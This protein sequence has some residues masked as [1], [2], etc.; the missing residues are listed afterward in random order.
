[1]PKASGAWAKVIGDW[2]GPD[3]RMRVNYRVEGL[4]EA[5]RRVH[6]LG[7]RIAVHA[8]IPETIDAAIEAGFDSIEHAW[9]LRDDHIASMAAR[10]I[11]LVPTLTIL[12]FASSIVSGF[13][14]GN[15]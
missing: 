2:P 12:P 11:T 5:A 9:G 7:A 3:G 6:A 15:H 10:R 8:I 4:A 1:M 13:G 14:V